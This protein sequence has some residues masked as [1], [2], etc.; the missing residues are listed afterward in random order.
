M[1]L[2]HLLRV[3]ERCSSPNQH[4]LTKNLMNSDLGLRLLA[5]N[6][7]ETLLVSSSHHQSENE[8]SVSIMLEAVDPT[9]VLGVNDK[10]SD[11]VSVI[12]SRNISYKKSMDN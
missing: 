8:E 7:E 11:R 10:N 5:G 3:T 4:E 1:N 6:N 12:T 9:I 2:S